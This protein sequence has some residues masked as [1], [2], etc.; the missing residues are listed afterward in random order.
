M[1]RDGI[2]GI[3]GATGIEPTV[4]TQ[5]WAQYYLV[6]GNEEY[7]EATH[8]GSVPWLVWDMWRTSFCHC[9]R[10]IVDSSALSN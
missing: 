5:K 8:Q 4:V 1:S 2:L 10:N 3:A 7:K 6:A 9:C